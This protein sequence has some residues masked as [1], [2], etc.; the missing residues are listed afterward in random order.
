MPVASVIESRAHACESSF[1][2]PLYLLNI[3]FRNT[4]GRSSAIIIVQQWSSEAGDS[5][6]TLS[7]LFWDVPEMGTQY[8]APWLLCVTI[9]YPPQH[10]WRSCS[11]CID[12]LGVCGIG[13]HGPQ[14]H[15]LR[16]P[17]SHQYCA[18]AHPHLRL[19]MHIRSPGWAGS[20][21]W[22]DLW[23]GRVVPGA[24]TPKSYFQSLLLEL[25]IIV[26]LVFLDPR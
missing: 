18:P 10:E 8:A 13:A 14:V 17:V 24:R 7:Y 1:P 21:P 5:S 3:P 2:F 15:H 20:M 22:H 25:P 4:P 16:S 19:F 6:V 11:E 23:P 26:I 9:L 12:A